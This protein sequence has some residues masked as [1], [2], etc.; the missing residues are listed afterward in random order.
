MTTSRIS[1]RTF[2]ALAGAAAAA[3]SI[4]VAW[5]SI[6]RD[7]EVDQSD[8]PRAAGIGDDPIDPAVLELGRAVNVVSPSSAP[9]AVAVVA[10][11]DTAQDL[12][13][14]LVDAQRRQS[15][16]LVDVDGWL[17]PEMLAGV[18]GALAL[19]APPAPG[20]DAD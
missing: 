4:G 20:E 1:R 2:V 6:D 9:N 11:R 8:L 12:S 15:W 17:L 10:T 19:A 7:D 16:P 18:A 14:A 3:A 13:T 5:F